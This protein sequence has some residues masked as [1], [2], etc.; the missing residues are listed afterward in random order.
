MLIEGTLMKEIIKTVIIGIIGIFLILVVGVGM[1]QF[2]GNQLEK[3]SPARDMCEQICI[4]HNESFY[5]ISIKPRQ[6]AVC[7]CTIDKQIN[8]FVM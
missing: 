7:Y 2:I 3:S 5:S 1:L 8:T 6:N 4:S